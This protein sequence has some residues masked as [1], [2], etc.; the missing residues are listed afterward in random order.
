MPHIGDADLTIEDLDES[1]L[2][3]ERRHACRCRSRRDRPLCNWRLAAW[4]VTARHSLKPAG[5]HGVGR[6]L[7]HPKHLR[8]IIWVYYL[9]GLRCGQMAA[10][11][12]A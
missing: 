12:S 6:Q 2:P 4:P 10:T 9:V 1:K 5:K 7:D 11:A 8:I 3:S